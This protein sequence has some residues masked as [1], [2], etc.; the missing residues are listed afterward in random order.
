M[1]F[2]S[3]LGI[4]GTLILPPSPLPTDGRCGTPLTT[5]AQSSFGPWL[6]APWQ[7]G[8]STSSFPAHFQ[9]GLRSVPTSTGFT[10]FQLV[11]RP[12]RSY[13]I[14]LAR[15]ATVDPAW[16]KACLT[17]RWRRVVS[18]KSVKAWDAENPR[19]S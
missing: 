1:R 15:I 16:L 10:W 2:E 4:S 18:K 6:S 8:M 13:P 9:A 3:A 7:M 19:G 14:V 5:F 12:F 17:P 11:L